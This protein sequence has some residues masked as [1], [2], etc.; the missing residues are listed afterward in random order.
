M[1]SFIIRLSSYIALSDIR[2]YGVLTSSL[3]IDNIVHIHVL[4]VC[5]FLPT[6]EIFNT[7]TCIHVAFIS[8]ENV[9]DFYFA[10]WIFAGEW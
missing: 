1:H 8:S 4:F 3:A 6:E 10:D 2:Y 9:C 5:V 7:C